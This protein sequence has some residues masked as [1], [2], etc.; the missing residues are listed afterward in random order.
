MQCFDTWFVTVFGRK[1]VKMKKGFILIPGAGMSDWIWTKLRPLLNLDSVSVPRRI[2]ENTFENRLNCSFEDI[3]AYATKIIDGSGFDEAILVAHSG[4]GIIAGE[5]GKRNPKVKHIVFLA[6]NIPAHGGTCL[7]SF[8]DE[9]RNKNIQ[10]IRLQAKEDV[11]PMKT[12]EAQFR[13]Y[14]CNMTQE[15]DI[16]YLLKQ[17]FQTEPVC[18]LTHQVNWIEYPPIE[19]TYI[20]CSEDKTLTVENQEVFASHMKITDIHLINSDHMIMISHSE[21]LAYKLNQIAREI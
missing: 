1:V 12:L 4:A 10:G 18:V 14:F 8:T 2:E 5:I 11:I 13:N 3:I 20:I 16:S 7:D 15:E 21:Q 6:A 9:I 19:K 17:N